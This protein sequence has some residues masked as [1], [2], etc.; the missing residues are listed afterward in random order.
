M[1]RLELLVRLSVVTLAFF[2]GATATPSACSGISAANCDHDETSLLQVTRNVN[3]RVIEGESEMSDLDVEGS[4]TEMSDSIDA[5]QPVVEDTKVITITEKPK[6]DPRKY[7]GAV[8]ENGLQVLNIQDTT[9]IQSA[10]AMAVMSGSYNDPTELPGLAHFCEHMLFLG[11]KKYP[12]AEEFDQFM[13][14]VGGSNNAYTD[15]EVTDYF[16]QADATAALDAMPRFANWFTEP[17]FNRTYVEKEVHAIDSEH[18]KNIQDPS[19][20]IQDTINHLANPKSPVSGFHTGNLNTLL[21]EPQK[22]GIDTVAALRE[23]FHEHYCAAKMRLVT[24]GPTSIEEQFEATKKAFSKIPEGSKSCRTP[25]NF[26]DPP[27]WPPS[28]LRKWVNVLGTTPQAQIWLMFPTPDFSDTYKS[29]PDYYL[30]YVFEYAGLN[31]LS[32]VLDDQLGLV[33]DLGLSAQTD[34]ASGKLYIILELTSEGRKHHDLI[35]DVV[36]SYIATLRQKGANKDLYD[37]LKDVT[38]LKWDWS[39]NSGPMNT[40]SDLAADLTKVPLS[41]VVWS[42]DV[43]KDVNTTLVESM[44]EKLTPDNMLAFNVDPGPEEDL[45]K[46]QDVKILAHY[47]VK[48]SEQSFDKV[49]PGKEQEW[50]DWVNGKTPLEEVHSTMNQANL[51]SLPDVSPKSHVP[52]PPG[53]IIGVPKDIPLDN[54]HADDLSDKPDVG[55]TEATFGPIPDH[56]GEVSSKS[57]E[58]WYRRG[59]V[60]KSPK[61]NVVAALQLLKHKGEPETTPEEEVEFS[62]YAT[63][64][65]K[66]LEPRLVDLTATGVDFNIDT[67]DL[68]LSLSFYGFT[69]NMDQL[70]DAVLAQYQDFL[71]NGTQL[72]PSARFDRAKALYV[73]NLETYDGMPVSYALADRTRLIQ[74]NT[75]SKEELLE[76]AKDATLSTTLATGSKAISSKALRLSSLIMGNI[77]SKTAEETLG[78]ITAGV[79]DAAAGVEKG[80]ADDAGYIQ[81]ILPIVKPSTPV[82][83]RKVNPRKGDPN[84]VVI[85]TMLHDVATI[86]NRV[87]FGL[88]GNILSSTAYSELRT[89]RQLGYVVN[90]GSIELSNVMAV[91]CVVQGAK[92]DA[93]HMEGAVEAVYHKYMPE[94]LKKLTD[95]DFQSYIHSYKQSLITPPASDSEEFANFWSAINTSPNGHCMKMADELLSSLETVTSK[96]LLIDTWKELVNPSGGMRTKVVVKYFADEVP[97]RPKLDHAKDIW[98]EQGVPESSMHLLSHEHSATT[99]VQESNTATRRK[100]RESGSEYPTDI[101]CMASEKVEK[102]TEA[103][104]KADAKKGSQSTEDS[105]SEKSSSEKLRAGMVVILALLFTGA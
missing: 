88:L 102:T 24:F 62:L 55:E 22:K 51:E 13:S 104:S 15:K 85:V 77:D 17:L 6:S 54:M 49:M 84:G 98:K 41:D 92:L 44:M 11:S 29:L 35:L 73:Q 56:L 67:S 83:L 60:T 21:K 59:W 46:G 86:K 105:V 42:S 2:G 91:S 47:G 66:H 12:D 40:V 16:F 50:A 101:H 38:K 75:R 18:N 19:W 71:A 64:L 103:G 7:Q 8:L 87:I 48:Y 39:G 61:V 70:I 90:A 100:L 53:P 9:S 10:M 23:Y 74:A 1:L 31:S 57:P 32:R 4:A 28:Q 80:A 26:A 79:P 34:T 52:V 99:L 36:F 14:K 37:S 25:Q 33:S 65:G 93:D 45:F 68:G 89:Q 63:L 72:T 94:K 97:Q 82:E 58:N 96:Q 27:A 43:I 78:H 81:R 30:K 95:D 69:P 20:R 5:P 76:A 3:T